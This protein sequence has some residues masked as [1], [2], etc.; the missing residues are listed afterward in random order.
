MA[1]ILMVFLIILAGI[2]V[3]DMHPP[4]SAASIA[5]IILLMAGAVVLYHEMGALDD[6]NSRSQRRYG[7]GSGQTQTNRHADYPGVTYPGLT[8]PGLTHPDWDRAPR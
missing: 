4:L 8:H 2:V 3:V 6:A 1:K 5:C 7:R